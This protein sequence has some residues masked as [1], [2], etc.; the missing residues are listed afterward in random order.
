MKRMKGASILATGRREGADSFEGF[1]RSEQGRL[2]RALF[3]VTGDSYVAEDIMQEAFVRL[4]ER[5]DRLRSADSPTGY[6]YT[7]ALNLVR[8]HYRRLALLGRVTP[9]LAAGNR[10]VSPPL[11]DVEIRDS[12]VRALGSLTYRQ[13]AALVLTEMLD[14]D[15]A[16]AGRLLGVKAVTVRRLASKGR[17]A[18]RVVLGG[19][20]N[21]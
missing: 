14:F 10:A 5:W 9:R 18:L 17:S 4:W 19:V 20:E 12:V 15:S 3:V 21:E 11:Y 7:T 1:F 6:L 16:E 8:R 13:R 2:L